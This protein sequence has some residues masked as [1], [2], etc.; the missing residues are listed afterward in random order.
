MY[1]FELCNKIMEERELH[2]DLPDTPRQ[3]S[4]PYRAFREAIYAMMFSFI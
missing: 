3:C 2:V 1:V 4:D